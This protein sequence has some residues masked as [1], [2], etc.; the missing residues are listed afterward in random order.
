MIPPSPPILCF[1]LAPSPV[2]SPP[3]IV[4]LGNTNYMSDVRAKLQIFFLF[5]LVLDAFVRMCLHLHAA[6]SVGVISILISYLLRPA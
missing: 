4:W 2:S 1:S 6:K 3:K 5:G